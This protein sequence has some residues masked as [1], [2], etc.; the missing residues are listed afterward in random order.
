MARPKKQRF[1]EGYPLPDNLY[2][3]PARRAGKWKYIRPDGTSYTFTA[4]IQEAIQAATDANL[5]R[6]E[7]NR[8]TVIPQKNTLPYHTEQFIA[9]RESTDEKLKANGKSWKDRKNYVRKFAKEIGVSLPQR[10]EHKPIQDW[11]EALSYHGQHNRRPLLMNLHD[12]D[13]RLFIIFN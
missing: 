13:Y 7:T 4:T 12:K 3:D 9:W 5:D 8:P 1:F 6:G 10:L 11:W 2:P